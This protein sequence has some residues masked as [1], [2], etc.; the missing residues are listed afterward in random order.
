MKK[1]LTLLLTLS[2]AC[3]ALT[4]CKDSDESSKTAD[5]QAVKAN[6]QQST[7]TTT[8][9]T[10]KT[11]TASTTEKTTTTTTTTATT[12]PETTTTIYPYQAY[13]SS[14][15]VTVDH[16]VE[17][18]SE[19]NKDSD[20]LY[21]VTE[22]GTIEIVGKANDEWQAVSIDGRILFVESSSLI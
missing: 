19:P 10:A 2:L 3:T 5:S 18:Y 6:V 20:L 12:T 14:E 7:T 16:L 13:D 22:G 21:V 1:L 11:T 15:L 17:V 8:T 4:A 9:T